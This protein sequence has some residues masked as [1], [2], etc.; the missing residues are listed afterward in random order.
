MHCKT[1]KAPISTGLSPLPPVRKSCCLL[2]QTPHFGRCPCPLS[3]PPTQQGGRGC[4]W[5]PGRASLL[6]TE[7]ASKQGKFGCAE[8]GAGRGN[9]LSARRIYNSPLLNL[10]NLKERRKKKDKPT[11][12]QL[13]DVIAKSLV[14]Q[15]K[16]L[17]IEALTPVLPLWPQ[18]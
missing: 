15:E 8:P 11:T 16:K 12:S 4:S 14:D 3:L 5:P 17:R 1:P 9:H 10:C 7:F 18:N 13:E 6:Q 2:T